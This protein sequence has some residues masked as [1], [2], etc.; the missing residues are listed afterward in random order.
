MYFFSEKDFCNYFH[1]PA[2]MISRILR[3]PTL[4]AF[5]PS[6]QIY[7]HD[8]PAK[9]KDYYYPTNDDESGWER[10]KAMFRRE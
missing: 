5:G 10:I 9:G 4:I 8:K 6:L 1:N 7:N 3:Y 2:K